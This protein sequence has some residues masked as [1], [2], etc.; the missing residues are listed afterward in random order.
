MK[1]HETHC[2]LMCISFNFF[3]KT[4]NENLYYVTFCVRHLKLNYFIQFL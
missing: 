1:A 2:I 4:F 3:L